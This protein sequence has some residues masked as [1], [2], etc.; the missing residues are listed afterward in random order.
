M[1][2]NRN[3]IAGSIWGLIVGDALGVPVEFK[4][5][6][7]LREKPV[8]GMMEYGTH[9]QPKGTWSDDS[10]MMLC[11]LDSLCKGEIDYDDIMSKFAGWLFD[12]EYTPCGET[13]DY[14]GASY[15]AIDRYRN[16]VAPLECGGR[17]ERDNGNGSLMRILPVV[18]YQFEKYHHFIHCNRPAIIQPVCRVSAL[19]H[20]HPTSLL[21]CGLYAQLLGALINYKHYNRY[22]SPCNTLIDLAADAMEDNLVNWIGYDGAFENY[23]VSSE[24]SRLKD[25]RS[26]AALPEDEIKSGGYVVNTLEAALWCFLNTDNFADCVLKAV[27]L[28]SDTDTTAAV[29]GSIAGAYYGMDGI[30][31]EWLDCIARKEWIAEMID[32]FEAATNS[33][34]E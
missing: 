7:Q 22:A 11:T 16:G 28:G 5:R 31:T 19:T 8:T 6:E 25:I 17:S 15:R 21:G 33:F 3:Y 2:N 1:I 34:S 4:D 13:F 24:Y 29:A 27:N 20:A 12:G 9:Y 14:G 23:F 30:P 32:K 26:F 18:L 10:S